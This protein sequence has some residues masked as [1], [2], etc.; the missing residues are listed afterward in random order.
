[1]VDNNEERYICCWC[2][3]WETIEAPLIQ[4]C[5]NCGEYGPGGYKCSFCWTTGH[6]LLT[7][8]EPTTMIAHLKYYLK[9][10]K[11]HLRDTHMKFAW[12]VYT[13]YIME[14]AMEETIW[15]K[16]IAEQGPDNQPILL[17]ISLSAPHSDT[18]KYSGKPM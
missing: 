6:I 10:R 1:M 12:Y 9:N 18:R 14:Q 2:T 3:E 13:M 5:L 4:E 16:T 7:E 8:E 17:G 15:A 11:V